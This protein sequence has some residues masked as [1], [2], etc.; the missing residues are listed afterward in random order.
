MT[1]SEWLA[2][3]DLHSLL[4]YVSL[5]P[6]ERKRRLSLVACAGRLPRTLICPEIEEAVGL[7]SRLAEGAGRSEDAD[8]LYIAMMD[9]A[10]EFSPLA[11]TDVAKAQAEV[12]AAI[13]GETIPWRVWMLAHVVGMA[14]GTPFDETGRKQ[15]F[16][17]T[18]ELTEA[19]QKEQQAAS[20]ILRDIYGRLLFRPVSLDPSWL[21]SD[22]VA[23]AEG[24][25]A[26]NAFDRMP[27]LADALQDAG[28]DS[29]DILNHCRQP[30]KH[31]RGCWVVD[32]LTGRK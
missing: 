2:C 29:P 6:S 10:S 28:C 21:T 13:V 24:I 19:I 8:I 27:I 20:E 5:T 16:V 7:V 9:R 25:Y 14:V 30:G 11:L 3:A 22:V 1:E 32:M 4:E 18:P 23:L 15:V 31:V 26:E 12:A 17:W